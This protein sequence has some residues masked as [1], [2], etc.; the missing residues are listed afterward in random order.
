[1]VHCSSCG[2]ENNNEAKFCIGCGKKIEK[3]SVHSISKT[4]WYKRWWVIIIF[5]LLFF[6]VINAFFNQFGAKVKNEIQS[7]NMSNYSEEKQSFDETMEQFKDSSKSEVPST[8]KESEIDN[9]HLG[10][11]FQLGNLKYT[12]HDYAITKTLGETEYLTETADGVFMV[13]DVTIEN[14]GKETVRFMAENVFSVMNDKQ[15]FYKPTTRGMMFVK[16]I[17]DF[18]V[19]L[20]PGLP[21]RGKIIFETPVDLT[22]LLIV[23]K[24]SDMSLLVPSSDFVIV[25][26]KKPTTGSVQTSGGQT[27]TQ[28]TVKFGELSL[29]AQG[30]ICRA[31]F[32][33]CPTG[34]IAVANMG[35]EYYPCDCVNNKNIDKTD[36]RE[37]LT[38]SSLD[39]AVKLL[40]YVNAEECIR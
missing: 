39:R 18:M 15:Q 24:F 33:N 30:N 37:C 10:D 13:F 26:W 27:S 25:S 12:I 20:Q 1:M 23:R 4:V 38:E 40:G 36:L 31:L 2:K 6:L 5:I 7:E 22:G 29:T 14:V 11:T 35:Q 3:K 32:P 16:P 17:L 19:E 28:T 21:K 9:Y 8:P 34:T